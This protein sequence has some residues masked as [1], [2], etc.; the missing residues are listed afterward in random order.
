[1]IGDEI[2]GRGYEAV[3][4]VIKRFAQGAISFYFLTGDTCFEFGISKTGPHRDCGTE[5]MGKVYIFGLYENLAVDIPELHSATLR[6]GGYK[7]ERK[8]K[9]NHGK[10]KYRSSHHVSPFLFGWMAEFFGQLPLMLLV[11]SP[12]FGTIK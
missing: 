10:H 11:D 3:L 6:T 9:Q 12:P 1:L 7:G 4:F 5:G 2:I 8:G